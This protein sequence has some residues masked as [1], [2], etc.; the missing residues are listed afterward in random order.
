[1]IHVQVSL[2]LLPNKT[3]KSPVLLSQEVLFSSCSGPSPLNLSRVSLLQNQAV[4]SGCHYSTSLFLHITTRP[5]SAHYLL[6]ALTFYSGNIWLSVSLLSLPLCSSDSL[7]VPSARR[8]KSLAHCSPLS[9]TALL[10]KITTIHTRSQ[11][12]KCVCVRGRGWR[13]G[14]WISEG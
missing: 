7:S 2:E 8:R 4:F 14:S 13:G 11:L 12:Y 6:G 3:T 1:M 9:P 5:R 10:H